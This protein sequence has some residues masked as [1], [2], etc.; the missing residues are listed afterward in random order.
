MTIDI[1]SIESSLLTA[2]ENGQFLKTTYDVFINGTYENE[3]LF[4]K[5]ATLHNEG[6][7]DAVAEFN[8]LSNP[9]GNGDFFMTRHIFE[10]ILPALN[11]SPKAV[12]DCVKHVIK[13]AG[14]DGAANTPSG[15]FDKYCNA[16]KNRPQEILN[17]ARQ[18]N[19]DLME[20]ISPAIIAGAKI[21]INDFLTQAIEL[22][23]DNNIDVIINSS[24]AIGRINYDND[25]RLIDKAFSALEELI[26]KEYND[27]LFGNILNSAFYIYFQD[28]GLK[29]RLDKLISEILKNQGEYIFFRV[30]YLFWQEQDK[31][32]PESLKVLMSFLKNTKPELAGTINII[33]YGLQKLFAKGADE[34]VILFLEEIIVKNSGSLSILSF[35]SI[36]RD[37]YQTHTDLLNKI[38]T[39]WFLSQEHTLWNALLEI[40]NQGN[41]EDILLSADLSQLEKK[42]DIY[43]IFIVRKAIGWF[44]THPLSATSFVISL[45]ENVPNEAIEEITNLL[46]NPLLINYPFKVKDYLTKNLSDYPKK[47]KNIIQQALSRIDSYIEVLKSVPEIPELFPSESQKEIHLEYVGNQMREGYKKAKQG[48]IIDFFGSTTLLYGNTLISYVDPHDGSK[49]KRI[50]TKLQKHGSNFEYPRS[51]HID[52]YGFDFTFRVFRNERII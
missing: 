14:N 3:K 13:E 12:M 45:L 23:K 42:D 46:F 31:I 35:E 6:K 1:D 21:N 40:I 27:Q 20:F 11:A 30:S 2:V 22:L 43:Y 34:D 36:S 41:M 39:R 17:I 48:S 51:E 9:M 19:E 50:L 7:I 25:L 32:H 16:D 28:E 5:I 33:D 38:T 47:T 49:F 44:F 4:N 8:K 26:A 10:K 37:L 24:W 15:A 18:A 52:P 29:D